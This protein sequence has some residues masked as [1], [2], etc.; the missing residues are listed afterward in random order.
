MNFFSGSRSSKTFKPKKNI[1]EGSHQHDLMKHAAATLGS[2]MSFY[3]LGS[4]NNIDVNSHLVGSG[5]RQCRKFHMFQC[6]KVEQGCNFD[7]L[8]H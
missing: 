2:G 4:N 1:P 5:S 6:Q 7:L 8:V 3:S